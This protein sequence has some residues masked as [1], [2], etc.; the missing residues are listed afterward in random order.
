M[1]IDGHAHVYAEKNAAKIVSSFT[2][3][4]HMEPTSSVGKGTVP[5]PL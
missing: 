3:L 2:E 1:I 5:C 4:H